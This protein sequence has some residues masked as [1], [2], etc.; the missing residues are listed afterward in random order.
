MNLIGSL[1]IDS[2]ISDKELFDLAIFWGSGSMNRKIKGVV[3]K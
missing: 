1:T 2:P 3:K